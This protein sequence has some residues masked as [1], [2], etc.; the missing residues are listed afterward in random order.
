[1][2]LIPLALPPGMVRRG[3]GC[4]DLDVR[5][6]DAA[7]GVLVVHLYVDVGDA[8]GANVVDTVAEAVAPLLHAEIGG[9][10]GLRILSNLPLRR[11]VRVRAA[12]S[13]EA[14]GGAASTQRTRVSRG[15][16]A[17]AAGGACPM[18][19]SS[20]RALLRENADCSYAR[21]SAFVGQGL[22]PC[23]PS[24]PT[25]VG[26]PEVGWPITHPT[27]RL[28]VQLPGELPGIL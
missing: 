12:V 17:P 13:A 18:I 6:L 8:M 3:G 10:I 1:V 20:W 15:P 7:E 22:V 21:S 14:V 24:A 11:L 16:A 2:N 27:G 9:Q 5:V 23:R 26:A 19:T 28:V 25:Q 4:R